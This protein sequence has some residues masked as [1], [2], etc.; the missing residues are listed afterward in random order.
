M[1]GAGVGV[2]NDR[3]TENSDVDIEAEEVRFECVFVNSY[4]AESVESATLL[5]S[6][7]LALKLSLASLYTYYLRA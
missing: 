5:K 2:S 4:D 6:C 7:M 3:T 1:H